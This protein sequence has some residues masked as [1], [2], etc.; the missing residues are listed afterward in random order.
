MEGGYP[1]KDKNKYLIITTRS[2]TRAVSGTGG[3]NQVWLSLS[4]LDNF[5]RSIITRISNGT[6][7]YLLQPVLLGQGALLPVMSQT[8]ISV[9]K[10]KRWREL[11]RTTLY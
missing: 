4:S 9:F 8:K 6:D 7:G 1:T 2:K 11:A 5:L 3:G 10:V